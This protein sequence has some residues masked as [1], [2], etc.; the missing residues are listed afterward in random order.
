VQKFILKSLL[1]LVLFLAAANPAK[2]YVPYDTHVFFLETAVKDFI[3][4]IPR[5][6]AQ[7]IYQN[8]YDFLRGMTFMTRDIRF[9]PAK[10]KDIEEIRREAFARLSRDIPYC[11][12]ALKGGDLKLDTAPANLAGRLGMIAYSIILLK[13]PDYPDVEFLEK[14]TMAFEE[15]I[16]EGTID[17]WVFYDGYGDF[18]CLG[19]LLER[20]KK[21]NVPDFVPVRNDLYEA[22]MREDTFAILRAPYKFNKNMVVTNIDCNRIY[23]DMLND[24]ADAFMYIWKCSGMDL[25]HP[26]YAAPP[27]TMISRKKRG[28]MSWSAGALS[29][30]IQAEPIAAPPPDSGVYSNGTTT[31]EGVY[32]GPENR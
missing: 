25:A 29:T 24:I 10:L 30:P 3:R 27:G 28:T 5:S 6:M 11:V 1:I 17:L 21:T 12:E 13:L 15:I 31:E 23:A 4:F 7:Y 32:S 19:E 16:F 18:K 9:S 2:A 8:R 14:F 20:L 26:S 22:F